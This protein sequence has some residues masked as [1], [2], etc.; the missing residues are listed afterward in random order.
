MT[1][2]IVIRSNAVDRTEPRAFP[3]PVAVDL[4][5]DAPTQM[6][7]R[8]TETF[9]SPEGFV[10]AHAAAMAA[11]WLERQSTRGRLWLCPSCSGKASA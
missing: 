1:M 9:T 2:G 8:G 10:G 6:F 4:A 5:C 3:L 11:G 7:C